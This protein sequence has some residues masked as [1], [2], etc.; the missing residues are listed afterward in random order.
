[1]A[2]NEPVLTKRIP[3]DPNQRKLVGYDDY[4]ATG[5]YA[6]LRKALEMKADDIIKTVTD[7]GLR[8]RGGA[9]FSAGQKWSFIP[10]EKKGLHYLAVNADESE[11]GTF[12]DRYL[13]DFDPHSML[14]GIAIASIATQCDVAYI[15]IRGEFHYEAKVLEQA[16]KEAYKK[17]VFG[18][19]GIFGSKYKL[20]C[21]VHRGAG[22]YI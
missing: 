17:K 10:K 18:K 15:F 3:L 6:A 9:G 16:L 7:S 1:M 4:V 14:E 11:P 2:F 21:Y 5:G 19:Q 8:G 13:L 12:K 20:E 22:A